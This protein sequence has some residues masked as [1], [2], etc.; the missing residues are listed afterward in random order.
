[1]YASPCNLYLELMVNWLRKLISL[2]LAVCS[3]D[4]YAIY[5]KHKLQSAYYEE[6]GALWI[7][8]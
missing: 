6:T 3:Y 1:M 8:R 4:R 2:E 5:L 7:L